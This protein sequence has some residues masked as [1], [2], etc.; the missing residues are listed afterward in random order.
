MSPQSPEARRRGFGER[1]GDLRPSKRALEILKRVGIGTYTDGFT[2]AG[3]LAYLSLVTLFPFFIVTA[4]IA[5][6]FGRRED[7][8]AAL[9]AFLRTVPPDV[10]K[11]L[12]QPV[13]DVLAARS[14]SLL[15]FG[16]IVG[17]WTTAGFIETLRAI[18]RQAYGV[19][20]STPFWRY[21]LGAI[22]MIVGA[23]ILAMAAFSFQVILAG[24][25]EFLYR[26]FPFASDAQKLVSLGRIAPALALFGAIYILF[27][28][29]TP[30][31][32][33]KTKCPKWPGAAFVA[34]W[35]TFTTA[36][37]P[38]V[39]SSLGGYDLTYGSLAGVMIALIFFFIIGLG[40]VIGAEL[41]AA[42][43]EVPREGLEEPQKTEGT[44]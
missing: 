25:E 30:A 23:V 14:G 22:G 39:L 43:A 38:A 16:A 12:A 1:L 32:Y 20:S 40:V 7:T 33:R 4:A 29:L 41:N 13:Q 26:V 36:S 15:W 5:R 18:L 34:G 19:Q 11:L 17:L 27:Y 2:H 42:L 9:N 6:V 8:I 10:A 35:W 28:S 3:N 31:R 37:L 21:R 44:A 24:V